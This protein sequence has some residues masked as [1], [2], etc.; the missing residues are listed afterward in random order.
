[1]SESMRRG[2][3]KSDSCEWERKGLGSLLVYFNTFG[4]TNVLMGIKL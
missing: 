1:M 3:R 4:G 2:E